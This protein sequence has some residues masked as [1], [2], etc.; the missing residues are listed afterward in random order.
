MRRSP[1]T[2]AP[3]FNMVLGVTFAGPA[4]ATSRGMLVYYHDAAGSYV[5]RVISALRRG[6]A[7]PGS[8]KGPV[9]VPHVHPALWNWKRM[10]AL[11]S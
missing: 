7:L 4:N 8:R 2:V 1:T 6:L 10:R 5:R 9:L 3:T 11:E